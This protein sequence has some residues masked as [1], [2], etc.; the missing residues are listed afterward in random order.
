MVVPT[1][2]T[3]HATLST[4]LMLA[5]W[6]ALQCSHAAVQRWDAQGEL[7]GPPLSDRPA[8]QG[9]RHAGLHVP[10]HRLLHHPQRGAGARLRGG[11]HVARAEYDTPSGL[12]A[13][14]CEAHVF[15]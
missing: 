13:G 5:L 3:V 15:N 6:P 1:D 7:R 9:A 8:G 14:E 2:Y 10:G 12:W 4:S 11:A